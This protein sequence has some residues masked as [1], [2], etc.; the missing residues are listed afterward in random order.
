MIAQ[1]QPQAKV[2]WLMIVA[3]AGLMVVGTCFIYSAT[4]ANETLSVLPWYR[5]LYLM[6]SVWY[7][8]GITAAVILCLI[9][10]HALARWSLV[11]YWLT[12]LLLVAV[13]I[14]HIGSMRFGARRWIDLGFFQIQ[15]S[16]F[17]KLSFIFA[18]A[19]FLSRPPDELRIPSV[20]W[21]AIGLLALPFVLIMKEPDLG[22]ALI[23]LPVGLSMLYVAGVP[24]RYLR[25][26]V[27]LAALVVTLIVAD[28][29]F[30]PPQ[31]QIKME[32]YQ[33]RRLLV[34][35]GRDFSGAAA[36]PAQKAEARRQSRNDSYNVEQALISVG[37]GGV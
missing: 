24:V 33:K 36:T 30:A 27:G 10:Y 13:L 18:R 11:I 3:I 22:S 8:V 15:P 1:T 31:W 29:L 4:M 34:Y 2:D 23:L 26:L 5:Q 25:Q 7:S 12:I 16:E 28:V 6:Q 9:D 19:H 21:K 37:S 35:F 20:F 32:Q 14:P 17:A